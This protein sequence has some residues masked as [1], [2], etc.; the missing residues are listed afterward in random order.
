VFSEHGGFR[1]ADHE[2][3]HQGCRRRHRRS[4]PYDGLPEFDDLIE[5][6]RVE[7]DRLR[8]RGEICPWVFHRDGEPI[9]RF[10]TAWHQACRLAGCPDLIPH[11]FRR[12]AVR[13]LIRAGVPEKTAMLLTGHTKRDRC[14]IGT[15][16]VNEDD[17]RGAV[18]RL[19]QTATSKKS[20]NGLRR[21]LHR[22]G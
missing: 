2:G 15:T 1:L 18:R 7:R 20:A 16:F 11:D 13:N 9:R 6:Q 5:A 21:P 14:S 17:L 3:G 10:D 12:T 4:S 22:K 19:A 8:A